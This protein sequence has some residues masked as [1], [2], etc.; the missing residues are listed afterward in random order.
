MRKAVLEGATKI[1][2]L[3]MTCWPEFTPVQLAP[4]EPIKHMVFGGLWAN[5]KVPRT[6]LKLGLN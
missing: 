3:K 4:L 6:S 2:A 5:S 1:N